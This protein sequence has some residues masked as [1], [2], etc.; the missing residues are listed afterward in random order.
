MEKQMGTQVSRRIMPSCALQVLFLLIITGGVRSASSA[1]DKQVLIE[2]K[3]FLQATNRVH[4]GAYD[5]W[6]ESENSP[7]GLRGVKCNA[8]GQVESLDLSSSSIF[9]PAFGNFSRLRALKRLDLSN[10]S[11][12]GLLRANDLRRCGGLVHLNLSQ[13]LIGGD[14]D[15]SGLARLQ[16]LDVSRNRFQRASLPAA[17]G[18][19]T[20]LN[21]STNNLTGGISE[22]LSN[23]V[24]LEHVVV[25][26]N[27]FTGQVWPGM[28]QLKQFNAAKNNLTGMLPQ[29]IFQSGCKLESLDLSFNQLRG[30]FPG[31]IAHCRDLEFL[32]LWGNSFSG[33]IPAGI[34][35][36]TGL[37]T[38]ILG[39]NLFDR[40][41]PLE[42]TN[43]SKLQYLDISKNFFGG[44][45]QNV[46]GNFTGLR[47]LVLHDNIYTGGIISSGILRLPLLARLDLSFNEFHGDL[48]DEVADMK[49]LM[50]LILSN[51]FFSGGIPPSWGKLN[52]LQ[53]L[54]LSYNELSGSIPSSIGNLTYLIGLMIPGNHLSGR[55]PPEIGNCTSLIYLNLEGNQLSGTIPPE[56]MRM[57]SD[58]WLTFAKNRNDS[59]VLVGF[60]ECITLV[61]W[62]IPTSYSLFNFLYSVMNWQSCRTLW[63]LIL[64]G[65]GVIPV[66]G[67]ASLSA[68]YMISKYVIL[69]RN[70]LSGAIPSEI[71][72]MQNLSMLYLDDNAL[73]G[74]LPPEIG[75]LPLIAFNVSKNYISGPVPPNISQA[76]CLE[77]L[78][79]SY[80]NFSGELPSSLS[81]LSKLNMFNASYNPLLSGQ[82]PT[83]GQFGTFD[84]R[85]F[86][87]D[88][89]IYFEKGN[90]KDPATGSEIPSIQ[91]NGV[92]SG[93]IEPWVLF[94]II[95][96]L[97]T[98]AGTFIVVNL[99][100]D[101]MRKFIPYG[102]YL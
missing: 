69:S 45:V 32:S 54:G 87:G 26:S 93:T 21:V 9:G 100:F 78:D 37:Q 99:K 75:N 86:I 27:S 50:Y 2:L 81:Q 102:N 48:P 6:S 47:H 46:F 25:S 59:T 34:G 22:W 23:C 41:I 14:L 4:R 60:G 91:G 88:P 15:V 3:H 7:C 71:A 31:S 97:V 83:G 90:G 79:L 44:D 10:N 19:L 73:S 53:L 8:A 38:L 42:L 5:S 63:S 66:C 55:I 33:F 11:I 98:G 64:N 80:N 72:T 1:G 101:A 85:S 68:T 61:T 18:R 57:G 35:D 30:S 94:S 36:I 39:N 84:E 70:K 52:K 16:T 95:V 20:V 13:N 89:N 82:V 76:A 65:Y 96:A 28:A 77:V 67:R 29:N 51:N 40:R 92:D 24:E 12:D 17:C 62:Y 49:S 74:N 56:M 43:C 58:P